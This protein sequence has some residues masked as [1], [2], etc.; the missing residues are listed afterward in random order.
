MNEISWISQTLPIGH[1]RV[2]HV[3]NELLFTSFTGQEVLYIFNLCRRLKQ[4]VYFVHLM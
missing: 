1:Q 2:V 3:W 4:V